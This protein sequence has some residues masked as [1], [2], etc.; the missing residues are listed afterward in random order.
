M[1]TRDSSGYALGANPTYKMPKLIGIDHARCVGGLRLIS[2]T[3]AITARLQV[4]TMRKVFT[5][6]FALVW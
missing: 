2:N 6:G 1:R 3:A 5:T 4:M